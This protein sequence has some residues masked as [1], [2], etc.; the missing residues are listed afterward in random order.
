MAKMY[1]DND[2]NLALLEG[3]KIAILGYG[4]QGH[5]QAHRQVSEGIQGV[6]EQ[7]L[8]SKSDEISLPQPA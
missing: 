4:S 8:L 5:A 3:K 2:A 7:A 1:Y 6:H